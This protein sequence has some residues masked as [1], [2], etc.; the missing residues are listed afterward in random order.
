[1]AT[2]GRA[3]APDPTPSTDLARLSKMVRQAVEDNEPDHLIADYGQLLAEEARHFQPVVSP[4]CI[5]RPWSDGF[6]VGFEV[7][8]VPTGQVR[9]LYLNP[10]TEG[11]E[12]PDGALGTTFLYWGG[13]GDSSRD[14]ALTYVDVHDDVTDTTSAKEHP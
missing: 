2:D 1:M 8:H 6:A 10:S 3:T 13:D 4:G 12:D 5:W 7:T 11:D 9:Y 14:A